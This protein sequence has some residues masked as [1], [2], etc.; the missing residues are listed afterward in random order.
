MQLS[1]LDPPWCECPTDTVKAV[2]AVWGRSGSV[3]SADTCLVRGSKGAQRSVEKCGGFKAHFKLVDTPPMGRWG[4]AS[5]PRFW[6]LCLL[7]NKLWQ[8]SIQ[9]LVPELKKP[10]VS[11]PVCL[12]RTLT[13][14]AHAVKKPDCWGWGVRGGRRDQ[15]ER[16]CQPHPCQLSEPLEVDSLALGSSPCHTAVCGAGQAPLAEPC[17]NCRFM[18]K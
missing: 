11:T 17:P 8:N 14:R 7:D 3:Y 4:S 12:L 1:C 10:A 2:R 16:N 15:V 9:F 13:F 6:V 18:S 5:S